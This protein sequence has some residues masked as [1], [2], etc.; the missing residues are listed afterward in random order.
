MEIREKCVRAMIPDNMKI[1]DRHV[2]E[3]TIYML[4]DTVH[5]RIDKAYGDI[6]RLLEHFKITEKDKS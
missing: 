5:E 4:P 1:Y 2:D 6:D 3:G